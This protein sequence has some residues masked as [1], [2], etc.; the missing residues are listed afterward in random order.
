M[1]YVQWNKDKDDS[2]FQKRRQWSNIFK[3]LK[4]KN[5]QP[6]FLYPAKISFKNESG[7]K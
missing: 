2:K 7:A 3:L 6:R 1:C 4:D 5:Y